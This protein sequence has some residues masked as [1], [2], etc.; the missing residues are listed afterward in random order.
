[1]AAN[2]LVRSKITESRSALAVDRVF[3]QSLL[4]ENHWVCRTFEFLFCALLVKAE[5][6]THMTENLNTSTG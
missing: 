5:L 6:H 2:H 3:Q 1:M 4:I